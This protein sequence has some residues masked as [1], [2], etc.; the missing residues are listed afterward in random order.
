MYRVP[1]KRQNG[2]GEQNRNERPSDIAE[3]GLD[4]EGCKAIKSCVHAQHHEVAVGEVDDPHDAENQS[5]PNAHQ[6]VDGADQKAGDQRLQKAFYK[7]CHR[8]PPAEMPVRA[9]IRRLKPRAP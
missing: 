4:A 1:E 3:G 2:S 5:K 6:T 7:L 8:E 9:A